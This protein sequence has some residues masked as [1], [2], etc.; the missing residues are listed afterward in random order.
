MMGEYTH[1]DKHFPL[2]FLKLFHFFQAIFELLGSDSFILAKKLPQGQI[3]DIIRRY[4][5]RTAIL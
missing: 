3:R 4:M 2:E 1:D 5:D